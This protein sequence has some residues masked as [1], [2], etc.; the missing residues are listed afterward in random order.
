MQNE[1]PVGFLSATQMLER[2]PVSMGTLRAM[3]KNGKI[4]AIRLKGHRRVLYDWDSVRAALLRA[5]RESE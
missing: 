3:T 2:L 1:T 5:Q 4:P